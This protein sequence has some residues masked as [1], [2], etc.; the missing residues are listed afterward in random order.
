MS[1]AVVHSA[2]VLLGRMCTG[3]ERI[4]LGDLST[5][6]E[7]IGDPSKRE[8][9]KRAVFVT[10][11]LSVA[12]L[13]QI[14]AGVSPFNVRQFSNA[15]RALLVDVEKRAKTAGVE[16]AKKRAATR[17]VLVMICEPGNGLD[18]ETSL[19]LLRALRDLGHVEPLRV[20]ANFWPSS[21][22]AH[23]WLGVRLVF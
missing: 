16:E 9:M 17:C 8:F 5:S 11:T 1:A 4:L 10:P 19:V 22:R 15:T 3:E 14:I 2:A 18:C 20:I 23:V 21:Q 6:L 12:E 13:T 7:K